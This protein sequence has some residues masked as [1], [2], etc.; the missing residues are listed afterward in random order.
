MAATATARQGLGRCR[1]VGL[2]GDAPF[3]SFKLPDVLLTWG[4]WLANAW[5][6]V[7][8]CF[9]LGNP[10]ADSGFAEVKFVTELGDAVW[11]INDFFGNFE[12]E[13]GGKTAMGWWHVQCPLGGGITTYEL[14]RKD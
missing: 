9:V 14:V 12:F 6:A 5:L 1:G 13:F 4:Q 3:F 8:F 11:W 2:R 7:E 10:A